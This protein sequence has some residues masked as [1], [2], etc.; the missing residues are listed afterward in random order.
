MVVGALSFAWAELSH[1]ASCAEGPCPHDEPLIVGAALEAVLLSAYLIAMVV[2]AV[3]EQ[4]R[5]SR[6]AD[7]T[8]DS[9]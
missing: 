3:K 7:D 1:D 2:P 5:R 8:P 6:H 9:R 4:R